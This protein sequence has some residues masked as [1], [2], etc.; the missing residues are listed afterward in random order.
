MQ[1]ECAS[2]HIECATASAF[3]QL[4]ANF[5]DLFC[6]QLTP[7]SSIVD[8]PSSDV[9][10]SRVALLL[11]IFLSFNIVRPADL[12]R[13]GSQPSLETSSLF[14]RLSFSAAAPI[15]ALGKDRALNI[16]DFPALDVQSHQDI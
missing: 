10:W 2:R 9:L 4:S 8:Y 6:I 11:I 12:L 14:E 1:P 7:S 5:L 13:H 3:A 16:Q 15:L